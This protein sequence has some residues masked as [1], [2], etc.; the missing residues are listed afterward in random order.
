M[1]TDKTRSIHWMRSTGAAL[2][3]SLA[4][5]SLPAQALEYEWGEWLFDVDTTLSAG[6]QWRT[7]SRDKDLA[8]DEGALNFN[9]GK[10][11]IYIE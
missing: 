8:F 9:D 6:A 4:L 7:E 11:S 2:C 1:T 5:A 3:G 10:G